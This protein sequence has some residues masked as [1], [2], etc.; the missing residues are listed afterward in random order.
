VSLGDTSQAKQTFEDLI[1]RN[2]NYPGRPEAER[3]LAGL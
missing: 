2:P 3:F 1:R